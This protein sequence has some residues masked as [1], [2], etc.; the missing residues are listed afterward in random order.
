MK[1]LSK[2]ESDETYFTTD[3]ELENSDERKVVAAIIV[4]IVGIIIYA[5]N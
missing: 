4:A 1:I 5:V 3:E 2:C